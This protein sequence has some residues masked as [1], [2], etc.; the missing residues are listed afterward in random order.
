MCLRQFMLSYALDTLHFLRFR[1]LAV[2]L[3]SIFKLSPHYLRASYADVGRLT[4]I[5][6]LSIGEH[7]SAP[8][9]LRGKTYL[10]SIFKLPNRRIKTPSSA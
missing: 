10:Y 2:R 8:L 4:N 3:Y 7:F 1:A 5:F 6:T 9:R